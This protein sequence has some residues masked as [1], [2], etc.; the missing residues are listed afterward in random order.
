MRRSEHMLGGED[1]SKLTAG[2]AMEN[3]VKFCHVTTS[4]KDIS[5]T[6]V[7]MGYG[8]LPVVDDDMNLIGIVSEF[9]LLKVLLEKQDENNVKAEDMMT[10][11]TI[12]V[13][14][15]TSIT[16]VIKILEDSK[17]IRVPVVKGSILV[18]ILTRRD[19]LFCYLQ[20]TLKPPHWMGSV[21]R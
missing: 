9:D 11:D 1:A 16:E 2:K 10:K 13:K 18:G 3:R 20:A 4:W 15:D 17:L 19:V 12:T 8:S 21:I 14:E 7:D 6:L 5:M